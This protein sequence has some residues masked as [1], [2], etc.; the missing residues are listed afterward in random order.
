MLLSQLYIPERTDNHGLLT[1]V[2]DEIEPNIASPEVPP[3]QCWQS[4]PRAW[5]YLSSEAST[6]RK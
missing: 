2:A 5:I 3:C 4:Q 1:C 6:T